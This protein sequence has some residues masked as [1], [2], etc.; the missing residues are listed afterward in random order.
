MR[1]SEILGGEEERLC[2]ALWVFCGRSFPLPLPS[3]SPAPAAAPH[4]GKEAALVHAP[5]FGV[6]ELER[7]VRWES[8]EWE[9]GGC[10]LGI[11]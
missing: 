8:E 1:C 9:A 4:P 3:T 10:Y 11:G 6:R 2:L 5:N 7:A